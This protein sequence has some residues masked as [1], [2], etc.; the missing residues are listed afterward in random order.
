MACIKTHTRRLMGQ[1]G[2]VQRQRNVQSEVKRGIALESHSGIVVSAEDCD[3]EGS[4]SNACFYFPGRNHF[5]FLWESTHFWRGGDLGLFYCSKTLQS[6]PFCQVN[7]R[8][9][10]G[11]WKQ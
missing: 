9:G 3:A 6:P 2:H 4:R 1:W 11:Q 8:N 7:N 10:S 5:L